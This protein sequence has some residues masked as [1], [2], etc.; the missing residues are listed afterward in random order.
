MLKKL[1]ALLLCMSLLAVP[2]FA[3]EDEAVVPPADWAVPYLMEAESLKLVTDNS[4]A[5]LYEI[6]TEEDIVAAAEII[7][8]KLALLELPL[9]PIPVDNAVV[10][11]Q[12]RGSVLETLAMLAEDYTWG[13]EANGI[14]FLVELGVVKGDGASLALERSCTMQE[15]Y[16][17]SA[18]F[19]L[20]CYDYV[21]AG[22]KGLLW[23]VTN[24][25][26]GAVLY[27]MGTYHVDMNNMYPM[28]GAVRTAVD[29]SEKVYFEL[30]FLDESGIAEFTALQ[31]YPE[32]ETL[33]DNIAPELYD[34]V[35]SIFGELGM[36]E[37]T[38]NSL[39]PWVISNSLDSLSYVD[40]TS[41]SGVV[42]DTYLYMRALVAGKEVGGIE[43][44]ALQ[45]SVFDT[46]SPDVQEAYL[47]AS[48][49]AYQT[50]A[51]PEDDLESPTLAD[52]LIAWQAGDLAGFNA[53]MDK[54]AMLAEA[55]KYNDQLTFNLLTLR[56]PDMIES[57]AAFL[58][59]PGSTTF[60][61]VG[62]LHMVGATGI[63][64]ALDDM[65]YTVEYL[66]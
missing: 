49:I 8:G 46:L 1:L 31:F 15:L 19:V 66:Y 22:S 63:V 44:Y 62:S 36:D 24:E 43:T 30:D 23:K 53:L 12:S 11:D 57:A 58:Q 51:E 20:A 9:N 32:G 59:A 27:L 34:A 3:T 6:V 54:D 60:L 39:K 42:V 2:A 50:G 37:T 65:G 40:E 47:A 35:V 61:A 55:E 41:G 17:L 48:V 25:Q 29:V 13:S 16:V 56:D 45:A 21:G 10:F 14:D 52:L 18:R 4:I 28:N 5:R 7:G 26:N 38:V 33:K 64:V